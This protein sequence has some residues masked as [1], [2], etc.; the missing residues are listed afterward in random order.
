MLARCPELPVRAPNT[1]DTD[2][3]L[4]TFS[5]AAVHGGMKRPMLECERLPCSAIRFAQARASASS[6]PSLV[7][8]DRPLLERYPLILAAKSDSNPPLKPLLTCGCGGAVVSLGCSALPSATVGTSVVV[9]TTV[10]VV[11]RW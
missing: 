10:V 7:N 11:R 2:P 3:P 1:E 4:P 5:P 9:G 8:P 6:E